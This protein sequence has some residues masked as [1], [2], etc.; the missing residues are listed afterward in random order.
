MLIDQL[1]G[2]RKGHQIPIV[3][4][5]VRLVVAVVAGRR[6]GRAARSRRQWLIFHIRIVHI[7]IVATADR[8]ILMMVLMILTILMTD[9]LVIGPF[10]I[11]GAVGGG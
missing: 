1:A 9:V 8:R 3:V 7:N 2:R 5:L 6:T 4:L 10:A 11:A